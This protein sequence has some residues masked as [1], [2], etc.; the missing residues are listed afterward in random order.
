MSIQASVPAAPAAPA[1]RSNGKAPE[2][3]HVLDRLVDGIDGDLDMD[4]PE[5]ETDL[6]E[7]QQ[8]SDLKPEDFDEDEEEK[9]KPKAKAKAEPKAKSEPKGDEEPEERPAAAASE[10]LAKDRG[11][12]EK[13]YTV[14]DLPEDKFVQ[15]KIDGKPATVSMKELATGYIRQETFHGV[16]NRASQAIEEA[17]TIAKRQLDERQALRQDVV[18]LFSTPDRMF[19]HMLNNHPDEMMALG[20]QIA[21]QYVEWKNNPEAL[22]SHKHS[23]QLRQVESE[24]QRLQQEKSAWETQQRSTQA[25]AEARRTWEPVYQKVMKEAGFP[26]L[27]PEFRETCEALLHQARAKSD[28]GKVSA[29]AFEA[30]FR[31]ALVLNK[32]ESTVQ[33]RTPAAP[34]NPARTAR[35]PSSNGK[36]DWESKSYLA[37]LRDPNFML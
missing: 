3:S 28:N 23:I 16:Y 34:N 33:N 22:A 37:R 4:G 36:K 31:R 35:Q 17:T 14:K 19:K 9:P 13:P 12:Q 30:C 5:R 2:T 1:A 21:A 15:V 11:T 10:A 26:K 6:P 8:F 25:Q 32:P 20:Q 27:T 24:R 18:A 7:K 29:E